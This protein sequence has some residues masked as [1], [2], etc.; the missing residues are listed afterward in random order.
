MI[1]FFTCYFDA[2]YNTI[3]TSIEKFYSLLSYIILI[4]EPKKQK[5]RMGTVSKFC[6]R[7]NLK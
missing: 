6:R 3:V 5:K 1:G 4:I 7:F 2:V